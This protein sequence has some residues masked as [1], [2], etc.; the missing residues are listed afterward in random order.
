[1]SMRINCHHVFPS[2]K[3]LIGFPP[4]PR[5]AKRTKRIQSRHK[6]HKT[7]RRRHLHTDDSR[8]LSL[9]KTPM[10]KSTPKAGNILAHSYQN[11]Y[12]GLL[13]GRNR[14]NHT[15]QYPNSVHVSL[16]AVLSSDLPPHLV[17]KS[18]FIFIHWMLLTKLYY[19]NGHEKEKNAR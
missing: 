16:I 7:H 19:Y 9:P 5:Q 8:L 1:M 12:M 13:S 6:G 18:V 11:R 3:S 14:F 10:V 4:P 15:P 17:G 2:R